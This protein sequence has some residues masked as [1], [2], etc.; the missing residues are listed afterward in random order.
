MK[1][2]K[3]LSAVLD[4]QL[5][6]AAALEAIVESQGIV[7]GTTSPPDE[8]P[9]DDLGDDDDLDDGLGDDDDPDDGLG[10]DDDDPDAE[11][12]PRSKKKSKKKASKKKA[13]KKKA[14]KKCVGRQASE[15]GSEYTADEVREKL[16]DVQ[17]TTGSA[18]QPKSILKKNGASTFGQLQVG[19]Y[20]NVVEACNKILDQY[21]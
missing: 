9:D 18:A 10:D 5:R 4:A 12:A 1:L 11:P 2:D 7:A 16:K 14:K 13:S 21:E 6:I 3:Y 19:R 15:A 20:D 8:N 17:I